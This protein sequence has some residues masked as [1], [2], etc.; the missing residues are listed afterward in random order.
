MLYFGV[1][2]T[3]AALDGQLDAVEWRPQVHYPGRVGCQVSTDTDRA[4]RSCCVQYFGLAPQSV[5]SY[6]LKLLK[7]LAGFEFAGHEVESNTRKSGTKLTAG[8][9]MHIQMYHNVSSP[10]SESR[11]CVL[12][13]SRFN[14]CHLLSMYVQKRLQKYSK[15]HQRKVET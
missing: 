9:T 14:F 10:P 11:A 4:L 7:R 15:L 1:A 2:E 6:S 8:A 13:E 5:S 12:K 3:K